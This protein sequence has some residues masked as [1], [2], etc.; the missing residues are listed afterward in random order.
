MKDFK[1]EFTEE[2]KETIR[3]KLCHDDIHDIIDY[4]EVVCAD[5]IQAR[6]DADGC[7]AKDAE[8][9]ELKRRIECIETKF[10]SAL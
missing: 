9:A 1:F 5:A 3:K 4:L 10:A 7:A 8:I 2:Q 6:A